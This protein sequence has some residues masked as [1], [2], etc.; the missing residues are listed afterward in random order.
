ME[1]K[2]Q[3]I[4][5][6]KKGGRNP[7]GNIALSAGGLTVG[8]AV[9]E[10][11]NKWRREHPQAS[12][13]ESDEKAQ[14]NSEIIEEEKVA[15]NT[16]DENKAQQEQNPEEN[17][18]PDEP[19][20]IDPNEP[21]KPEATE[22]AAEE[23]LDPEAQ[24]IAESEEMDPVDDNYVSFMNV[25]EHRTLYTENGEVD[26]FSIEINDPQLAGYPFMIADTDG[27]GF[28][29]SVLLAD[30]SPANI[31]LGEGSDAP[32]LD[33][34]LAMARISESDLEE[35]HETGGGHLEPDANNDFAQ[36]NDDPTK[37]MFDEHGNNVTG[38]QIAQ[39]EQPS[40]E[41]AT[42]VDDEDEAYYIA[43]LTQLLEE[44]DDEEEEQ[45]VVVIDDPE[46]ENEEDSS[47]SEDEVEEDFA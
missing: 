25:G 12:D 35:M 6:G 4:P 2:K 47:D 19:Q 11:V 17:N 33:S 37:D 43:L 18:V 45:E 7:F 21:Q 46:D 26:V 9:T 27:D 38:E 28:Y 8:A 5:A 41:P 29:D 14:N 40:T 22:H 23:P 34:F 20:P 30:G 3:N 36:I 13:M 32:T 42:D 16:E 1:T 10:A 31:I 24:R 44:D 39:N 15:Q